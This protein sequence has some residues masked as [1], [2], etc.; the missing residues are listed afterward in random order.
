MILEMS[1]MKH[2]WI[3][4]S[5][6]PAATTLAVQP[7]WPMHKKLNLIDFAKKLKLSHGQKLLDI[8]CGWGGLIKNAC[9]NYGVTATGISISKEQLSYAEKWCDGLPAKFEFMDYRD[10]REEYDVIVSVGMF[11]HVGEAYYREYFNH[12]HRSLKKHGIFLLHTIGINRS[13]FTNPWLQKYIFPG[14]FLPSLAH[15]GKANENLFNLEHFENFGVSYS[16]TLQHWCEN[17]ENAWP[18][19][20]SQY[21]QKYDERFFR[22]WRYYILTSSASFRARRSQLWQ[23]VFSK[24]GLPQGYVFP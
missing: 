20:S 22:M 18:Q 5:S 7:I 11:E 15:I 16:K 10:L 24:D 19:L 23:Y 13:D 17:F 4:I 14:G 8:V 3:P 12:V 9:E 6:I 2:F 21:P 1:Y